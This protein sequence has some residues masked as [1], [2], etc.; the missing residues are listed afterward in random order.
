[1]SVEC[2]YKD[3]M[4]NVCLWEQFLLSLSGRISST[5]LF[6][7]NLLSLYF[8]IM[9]LPCISMS[10]WIGLQKSTRHSLSSGMAV[11][12]HVI[13]KGESNMNPASPAPS[14]CC[15]FSQPPTLTTHLQAWRKHR[16]SRA[17]RPAPWVGSHPLLWIW[18]GWISI[19]S[20]TFCML[21][22]Y[23]LT[24]TTLYVGVCT[25]SLIQVV[26]IMWVV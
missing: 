20:L 11:S 10:L 12:T 1:M 23:W 14:I 7:L 16:E 21:V 25:V 22:V 17:H 15:P 4:T 24:V 8:S 13:I 3:S 2:P 6:S 18:V 5:F 9:P 19:K 26:V